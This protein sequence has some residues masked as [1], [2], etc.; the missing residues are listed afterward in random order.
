MEDQD[1]NVALLKSPRLKSRE[2]RS[3][4][5]TVDLEATGELGWDLDCEE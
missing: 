4:P 3:T 5:T 1:S 2:D